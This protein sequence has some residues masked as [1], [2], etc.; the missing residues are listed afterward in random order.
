MLSASGRFGSVG[1]G[2]VKGNEQ[3]TVAVAKQ[4]DKRWP[5]DLGSRHLSNEMRFSCPLNHRLLMWTPKFGAAA[6]WYIANI[7]Y[8][9]NLCSQ[10]KSIMLLHGHHT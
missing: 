7:I 10:S 3:A 2:G 8:I 5:C 4:E 6:K 9:S 1:A